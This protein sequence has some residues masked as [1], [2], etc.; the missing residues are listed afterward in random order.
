M[1]PTKPDCI[2]YSI[3]LS[4][5]SL[6]HLNAFASNS[7]FYITFLPA[8]DSLSLIPVH[9]QLESLVFISRNLLLRLFI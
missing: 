9:I 6:A 7:H 1:G 8:A 2:A 3:F 4:L 5:H